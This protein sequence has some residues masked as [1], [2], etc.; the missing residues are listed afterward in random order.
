MW[1]V[2]IGKQD[3]AHTFW[4]KSDHPLR[5]ALQAARL[6]RRLGNLKKGAD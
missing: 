6:C 4:C 3:L 5:N 1:A 2:L